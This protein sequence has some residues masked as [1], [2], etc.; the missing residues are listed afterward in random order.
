MAC[1]GMWALGVALAEHGTQAA[2]TG[3]WRQPCSTPAETGEIY[4]HAYSYV[5]IAAHNV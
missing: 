3:H 1:K 4:T 5:L 2:G